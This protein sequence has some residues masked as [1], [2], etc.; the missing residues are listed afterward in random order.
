MKA[1][2]TGSMADVSAVLPLEGATIS[3]NPCLVGE[4]ANSNLRA[5]RR[6]LE[7]PT[8][9]KPDPRAAAEGWLR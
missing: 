3:G 7:N 4:Q 8:L 1:P 6:S 2:V 5:R 9:A